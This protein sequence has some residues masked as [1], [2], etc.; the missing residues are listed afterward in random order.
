MAKA[1]LQLGPNWSA[2]EA[3]LGRNSCPNGMQ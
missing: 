2:I 1:G 3:Q